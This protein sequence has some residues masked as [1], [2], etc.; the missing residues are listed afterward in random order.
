MSSSKPL[1]ATNRD[2]Y[3]SRINASLEKFNKLHEYRTTFSNAEH[4]KEEN[5]KDIAELLELEEASWQV[6]LVLSTWISIVKQPMLSEFLTLYKT[7]YAFLRA[8][9][10]LNAP[11]LW[12]NIAEAV[13]GLLTL[14]DWV[15]ETKEFTEEQDRSLMFLSLAAQRSEMASELYHSDFGY[16]IALFLCDHEVNDFILRNDHSAVVA[17]CGIIMDRPVTS[18][19]DV[20][21]ILT[22]DITAPLANGTL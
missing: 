2:E 8:S 21:A 10:A 3:L 20:E 14:R 16:G 11:I 15:P 19:K 12:R 6:A 22:Q 9:N 1:S 17:A 7:H 4:L 5:L 13:S 18:I